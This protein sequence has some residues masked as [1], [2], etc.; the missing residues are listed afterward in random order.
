MEAEFIGCTDDIG[1]AAFNNF[2]P[3]WKSPQ[4][5]LNPIIIEINIFDNYKKI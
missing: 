2:I 5:H 1:S 4:G 3:Y